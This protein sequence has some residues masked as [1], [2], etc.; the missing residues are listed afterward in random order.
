[1]IPQ[2]VNATPAPTLDLLSGFIGAF[3]GAATTAMLYLHSRWIS[4]RHALR[5]KLIDLK[6]VEVIQIDATVSRVVMYKATYKEVW[7]LFLAYRDSLPFFR[8]SAADE[9][10]SY[11]K[12]IDTTHPA[13]VAPNSDGM[14][15]NRVD[16]LLKAIGHEE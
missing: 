14:V 16:E 8:R 9:A 7:V 12:G 15:S 3:L 2:I 5:S 1:M 10:W 13:Y 11:Y 4:A 6:S